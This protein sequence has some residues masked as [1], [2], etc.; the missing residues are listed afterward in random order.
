M[1]YDCKSFNQNVV[2]P[3]SVRNCRN[4]FTGCKSLS[5]KIVIPDLVTEHEDMFSSCPL[6]NE[7]GTPKNTG[8]LSDKAAETYLFG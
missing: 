4:M 3:N 2:I 5:K 6:M 8:N 7:D 1:F